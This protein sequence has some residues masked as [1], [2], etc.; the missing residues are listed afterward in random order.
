MAMAMAMAIA[1][2]VLVLGDRYQYRHLAGDGSVC[3]DGEGNP[4]CTC[5]RE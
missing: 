5:R 2:V 1:R 4:R 3:M